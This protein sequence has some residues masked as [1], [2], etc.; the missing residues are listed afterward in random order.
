ML[1]WRS[2]THI[3]FNGVIYP[4][5]TG[6]G[7]YCCG[8]TSYNGYTQ[9]CCNEIIH[10]VAG[11]TAVYRCCGNEPYNYYTQIC[12]YYPDKVYDL[13][14]NKTSCCYSE[15]YDQYDHMCCYDAV[16]RGYVIQPDCF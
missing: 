11:S 6:N 12:C 9:M 2:D 10:T 15:I 3:C 14:G 1:Q 7:A 16:T 4:N 5:G 8:D 13:I